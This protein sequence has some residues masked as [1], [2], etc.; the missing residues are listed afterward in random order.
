MESMRYVGDWLGVQP[1]GE[2]TCGL[3]LI[4]MRLHINHKNRTQRGMWLDVSTCVSIHSL[5]YGLDA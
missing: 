5:T 4:Q 1:I 2:L 3:G